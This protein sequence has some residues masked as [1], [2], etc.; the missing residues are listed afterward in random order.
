MAAL[1]ITFEKKITI[2]NIISLI[3]AI[4]VAG[5]LLTSVADMKEV[6]KT[7]ADA[8]DVKAAVLEIQKKADKDVLSAQLAAMSSDISHIREIVEIYAKAKG[9]DIPKRQIAKNSNGQ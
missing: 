1:N 7:K 4:L 5:G 9:V 3:V 8:D 6:I 2:G